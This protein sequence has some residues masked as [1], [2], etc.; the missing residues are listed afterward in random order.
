MDDELLDSALEEFQEETKTEI[1]EKKIDDIQAVLEDIKNDIGEEPGD[2]EDVEK[3]MS[4]LANELENNQELKEQIEQI[5]KEFFQEG[6][7]KNSM[8]ELRDKLQEYLSAHNDL[9]SSDKERYQAQL[10]IYNQ[11]CSEMNEGREEAAMELIGKLSYH[12]ELPP[13]LLPP[14]PEDCSVM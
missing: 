2:M 9:P 5:G 11:I 14:M 6:A 13:E 10:N 8:E 3:M 7:V 4:N 1:P 12:G